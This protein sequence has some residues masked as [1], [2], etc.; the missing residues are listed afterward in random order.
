MNPTL[1]G[2]RVTLL[3]LMVMALCVASA[4]PA[5]ASSLTPKERLG[6]KLLFDTNLST[7]RG[8]LVR[9]ATPRVWDTRVRRPR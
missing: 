4:A 1:K 8:R 9:R 3:L 6:K 7:P 2:S 5:A